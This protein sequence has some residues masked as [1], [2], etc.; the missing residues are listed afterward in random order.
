MQAFQKPL[1]KVSS[2]PLPLH[3]VRLH[4]AHLQLPRIMSPI[5]QRTECYRG[6]DAV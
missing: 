6:R 3:P 4:P 1:P 5:G 2:P